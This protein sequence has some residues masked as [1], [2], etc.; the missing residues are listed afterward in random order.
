MRFSASVLLAAAL[1]TVALPAMSAPVQCVY[2]VHER[3]VLSTK[4][5]SY[6]QIH[7]VYE[8]DFDDEL[9]AREPTYGRIGTVVLHRP[10][11]AREDKP[12]PPAQG[13]QLM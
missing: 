4:A 12:Q 6:R 8:R 9:M 1:S 3:P 2:N 7:E 11:V 10:I 13:R 5:L